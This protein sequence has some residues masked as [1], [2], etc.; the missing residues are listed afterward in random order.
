MKLNEGDERRDFILLLEN[1]EE[2]ISL[3]SYFSLEESISAENYVLNMRKQIIYVG[4]VGYMLQ[5]IYGTTKLYDS[6]LM[7]G[8][9][10]PLYS[11]DDFEKEISCAV[12]L[13]APKT[14]VILPCRHFCLCRS[15]AVVLQSQTKNC[16]ICRK[17]FS[18]LMEISVTSETIQDLVV[19]IKGLK[20]LRL[21]L[22][23][24]N[25]SVLNSEN[26]VL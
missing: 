23:S 20:Y 16:A 18:S 17:P 13:S 10:E 8:S 25:T 6:A 1:E 4:P 26:E 21:S 11:S 12:C 5:E 19:E 3:V 15:C 14:T 7:Y 24:R 9:E 22:A 2:P